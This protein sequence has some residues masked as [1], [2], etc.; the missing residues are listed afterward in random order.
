MKTSAGVK[1]Q[2]KIKVIIAFLFAFVLIAIYLWEFRTVTMKIEQNRGQETL[3]ELAMQGATIAKNKI[4]SS[5]SILRATAR[6]LENEE[7]FQSDEVMSYLKHVVADKGTDIRRIGSVDLDGNARITDGRVLNLKGKNIFKKAVEGRE[8]VSSLVNNTLDKSSIAIAVPIYDLN[9]EVK[10]VIYG[11]IAT[12]DFQ[13]YDK[14]ESD[15]SNRRQYIHIIDREGNVIYKAQNK[16]SIFDTDNIFAELQEVESDIPVAKIRNAVAN[17]ETISVS[18]KNETQGRYLYF[19]PMDI[20]RWYV[21][22]VLD[23]SLI[24][25]GVFNFHKAVIYLILKILITLLLFGVFYYRL[26]I[27]EKNKLRS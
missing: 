2:Q 14:N 6:T 24:E 11:I 7:D 26:L 20:N 9:D 5:V 17:Q 25:A 8:Y 21:V 4:D 12:E 1:R 22:A 18:M 16:N 13:L 10:G 23:S 3:E 19:A 15:I 27:E